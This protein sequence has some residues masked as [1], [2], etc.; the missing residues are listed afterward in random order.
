MHRACAA[1]HRHV[2][3]G[4]VRCT[5][6]AFA[7]TAAANCTLAGCWDLLRSAAAS[8]AL[9]GP[10]WPGCLPTHAPRTPC[11]AQASSLPGASCTRPAPHRPALAQLDVAR[12]V[13]RRAPVLVPTTSLL[14]AS[15][16]ARAL[17]PQHALPRGGIYGGGDATSL[18][19][20]LAGHGQDKRE[21]VRC[22][23]S[24]SAQQQAVGG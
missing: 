5:S 4:S 17:P 14:P 3:G 23:S 16:P 2:W 21:I 9:P 12:G 8:A 6:H 20:D 24:P 10:R 18:G 1:L 22:C 19:H 11:G 13:R 7:A 15:P